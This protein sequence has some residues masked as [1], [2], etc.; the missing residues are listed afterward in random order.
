MKKTQKIT[1]LSS[2]ILVALIAIS[3][4]VTVHYL[5]TQDTGVEESAAQEKDQDP[6]QPYGPVIDSG[7]GE[8]VPG[9]GESGKEGQTNEPADT[10]GGGTGTSSPGQ[11]P[12]AIIL[13]NSYFTASDLYIVRDNGGLVMSVI[14]TYGG[15]W[16]FE[17]N[18]TTGDYATAFS[19]LF[20][21][22]EQVIIKATITLERTIKRVTSFYMLFNKA[23]GQWWFN[24]IFLE[25]VFSLPEGNVI[26]NTA[27]KLAEALEIKDGILTLYY[28]SFKEIA[29][30]GQTSLN[31]AQV[32][33]LYQS[34]IGPKLDVG[35][36]FNI[37]NIGESKSIKNNAL[38]VPLYLFKPKDGYKMGK[39][40]GV[41]Y[42]KDPKICA[43][44][45]STPSSE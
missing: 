8:N 18:P 42:I 36:E 13:D 30:G 5:N 12:K 24:S 7:S 21:D 27:S 45:C 37:E 35:K 39:K 20:K 29:P 38:A 4:G 32:N 26:Q 17:E 10:D 6:N 41:L 44:D 16:E 1:I 3:A 25:T 43:F 22:N 28:T 23:E 40:W 19:T 14:S 9:P 15:T 11:T 34:S 2:F 33:Q 31:K